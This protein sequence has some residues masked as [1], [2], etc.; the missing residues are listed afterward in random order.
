VRPTATL[1]AD[2]HTVYD[3]DHSTD[4]LVLGIRGQM[5]ELAMETSI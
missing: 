3:P 1:I 2:E 4:R 5:S